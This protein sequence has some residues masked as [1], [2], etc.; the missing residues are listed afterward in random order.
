MATTQ[1]MTFQDACEYLFNMFNP[2]VKPPTG[3]ELI[4]AKNATITA[5]RELPQHHRW[6]YFMRRYTLSTDATQSTG[7]V[8]YDHTGGAYER[9]LTLSGATWPTNAARGAVRIADVVYEIDERKSDTVVTLSEDNNPG[10]DLVAG[11]TY[12]WYR[13]TYTLPVNFR[14]VRS[15]GESGV[16]REDL[17]YLSPAQ[18]QDEMRYRYATATGTPVYYTIR[19][20]RDYI[21]AMDVVFGPPP[22]SA[23]SYDMLYDAAPREIVTYKEA[24]GTVSVVGNATTVTGSGTAFASSH[25]GS[26][27]R[28][29]TSTT[30]EPTGIAG[31]VDGTTNPF[32]AQRTITAVASA[33]SCTIDSAVSSASLSGTK[34][35]ISDPIDIEPVIMRSAFEA[36]CASLYARLQ[37]REDASALDKEFRAKLIEAMGFDVRSWQLRRGYADESLHSSWGNVDVR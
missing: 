22:A 12:S 37:K 9:Q 33:T 31:H 3:R 21:G 25:V 2:A 13:D 8:A 5:L 10:S 17:E 15:F 32:L 6:S 19:Q 34:F 20:S 35:V 26:V 16:A 27:I 29:T 1:I 14:S 4:A 11:T 18:F 28:F 7:T 36:L 30:L 23:V 24:T